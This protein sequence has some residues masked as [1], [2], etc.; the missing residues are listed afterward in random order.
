MGILEAPF[1]KV[2]LEDNRVQP[3]LGVKNPLYTITDGFLQL[4]LAQCPL[5]SGL[6]KDRHD[7]GHLLGMY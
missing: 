4:A 7:H 2:G 5:T 1:S 3:P 6:I